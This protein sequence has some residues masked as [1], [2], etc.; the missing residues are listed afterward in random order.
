MPHHYGLAV[1]K[2]FNYYFSVQF[3]VSHKFN[4]IKHFRNV[5]GENNSVWSRFQDANPNSVQG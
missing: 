3:T 5:A 4:N 2:T 1:G